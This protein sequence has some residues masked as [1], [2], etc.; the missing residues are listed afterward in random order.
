MSPVQELNKIGNRDI[1]RFEYIEVRDMELGK[2]Y[3][4]HRLHTFER[5]RIQ[6]G[7]IGISIQVD[8]GF[9][10]VLPHRF[11]GIAEYLKLSPQISHQPKNICIS[12]IGRGKRNAYLIHFYEDDK[13]IELD[14]N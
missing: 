5:K 7:K 11:K 8:G 4:I 9:Q 3:K 10:L 12:Y 13:L 1:Q 6:A 2:K 14:S